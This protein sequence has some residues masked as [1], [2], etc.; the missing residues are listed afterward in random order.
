MDKWSKVRTENGYIG[1]VPNS[2]LSKIEEETPVSGFQAPV[3]TN[4]SLDGKIRLVSI[5]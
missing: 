5:R 3:Y 2:R 4:I 1:Y